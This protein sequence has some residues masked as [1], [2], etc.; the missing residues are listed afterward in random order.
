MKA[1]ENIGARSGALRFLERNDRCP[2]VIHGAPLFVFTEGIPKKRSG[3]SRIDFYRRF[4]RLPFIL[5]DET[6]KL[7][8][9][10]IWEAE[11]PEP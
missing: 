8:A 2:G 7:A 10:L 1:L 5:K 6:H 4:R 11:F 9:A 3:S